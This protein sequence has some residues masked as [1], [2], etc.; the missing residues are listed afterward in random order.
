M[1]TTSQNLKQ[2]VN[3]LIDNN[4]NVEY[5]T[6]L[7]AAHLNVN[8]EIIARYTHTSSNENENCMQIQVIP[9]FGMDNIKGSYMEISYVILFN[10]PSLENKSTNAAIKSEREY[11][12]EIVF[13]KMIKELTDNVNNLHQWSI[14]GMPLINLSFNIGEVMDD[15]F[16]GG[17]AEVHLEFRYYHYRLND[18]DLRLWNK[19]HN[20]I[21][22]DNA[23]NSLMMLYNYSAIANQRIDFYYGDDYGDFEGHFAVIDYDFFNGIKNNITLYT[24]DRNVIYEWNNNRWNQYKSLNLIDESCKY[25][26]FDKLKLLNI[27]NLLMT[28]NEFQTVT[29]YLFD[30]NLIDLNKI[31]K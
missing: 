17:Y 18:N 3:Q 22:M 13:S 7:L 29:G 30:K 15:L 6:Y 23:I 2:I 24:T 5:C 21:V 1:K 9:Y 10:R 25:F 28:E 8:Q 12:Y 31:I 26:E 27:K 11:A 19:S 20:I 14:M 4:I 16:R